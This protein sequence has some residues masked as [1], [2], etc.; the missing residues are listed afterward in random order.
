MAEITW[1]TILGEGLAQAARPLELAR[2]S[3]QTGL[4]ALGN[5]I[6]RREATD[7]ANV[8]VAQDLQT[9]DVLDRVAAA[10]TTADVA[11]LQPQVEQMRAGMSLAARNA[12]RG[13]VDQR[14][15]AVQDQ[16]TKRLAFEDAER[17]RLERP[18]KEEIGMLALKDPKAALAMLEANPGI[19]GRDVAM[20]AII[21]GERDATKWGWEVGNQA[22]TV[23]KQAHEV[24]MM[25]LERERAQVGIQASRSQLALADQQR[26]QGA[27]TFQN[28][29]DDRVREQAAAHV[30]ALRTH[31]KESGN[32][33]ADGVFTPARYPELLKTMRENKIGD[34]DFERQA[35]VARLEKFTKMQVPVEKN[36]KTVLVDLPMPMD[37]VMQAVLGSKDQWLNGRHQ[38]WANEVEKSLDSYAKNPKLAR[39]YDE[40]L[41]LQTKS[42]VAPAVGAGRSGGGGK[43]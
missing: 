41:E 5:V 31:L 19:K 4:D 27:T 16:T 43:K 23:A 8:K 6:Q 3:F 25:P 36:G 34:D 11:A 24:S 12:T 29:Q 17:D 13:A 18:I 39:Q 20:K 10:R 15:A 42:I 14:M 28:Q 30:S 26:T 21:S 40:F 22:H 38:G 37:R 2:Q 33:Y 32:E 35:I 7:A 9:A 1:R